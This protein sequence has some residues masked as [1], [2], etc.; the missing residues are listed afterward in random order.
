[1]FGNDIRIYFTTYLIGLWIF[2]MDKL[3]DFCEMCMEK[4]EIVG[5]TQIR[6]L[7]KHNQAEVHSV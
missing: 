6:L 5:K 3:L 7:I 4:C 1:M 2:E